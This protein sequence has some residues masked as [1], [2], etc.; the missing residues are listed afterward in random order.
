MRTSDSTNI[1][2]LPKFHEEWSIFFPR[3]KKVV[4]EEVRVVN[5]VS[6]RHLK[7]L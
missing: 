1:E 4:H 6:S 5:K 3:V 2:V 7:V